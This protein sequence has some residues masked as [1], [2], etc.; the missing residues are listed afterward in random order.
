MDLANKNKM[1]NINKWT[2]IFGDVSLLIHPLLF[3]L[4]RLEKTGLTLRDSLDEIYE[5]FSNFVP[6]SAVSEK[7]L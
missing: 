5:S 2:S 4:E 7:A 3:S 6:A 1:I